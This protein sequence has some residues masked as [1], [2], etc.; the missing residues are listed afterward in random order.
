MRFVAAAVLDSGGIAYDGASMIVH[1][2]P[3]HCYSVKRDRHRAA[4]LAF[5]TGPIRRAG[6]VN[7]WRATGK[8]ACA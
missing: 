8:G 6:R 2:L 3:D 5:V 4:R 7:G 1:A